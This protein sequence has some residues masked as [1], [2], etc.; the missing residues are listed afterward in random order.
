MFYILLGN[1]RPVEGYRENGWGTAH[2]IRHG[3]V[4]EV[5]GTW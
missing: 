1:L 5:S 3:L 2:I 4:G